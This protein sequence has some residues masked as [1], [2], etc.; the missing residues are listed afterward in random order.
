[1]AAQVLLLASPNGGSH[2]FGPQ[3]TGGGLSADRNAAHRR[4]PDQ[5]LGTV[6]VL[7]HPVFGGDEQSARIGDDV[8][9]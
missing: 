8:V 6:V 1:M 4:I 2:S 9:T 5:P 3:H 7:K